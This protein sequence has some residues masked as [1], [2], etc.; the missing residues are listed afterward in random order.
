MEKEFG[1]T[2][3]LAL[4]LPTQPNQAGISYD[5]YIN[6][7]P[8]LCGR[9]GWRRWESADDLLVEEFRDKSLHVSVGAGE[10]LALLGLEDD[11]LHGLHLGGRA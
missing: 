8:S 4:T 1:E 9:V 2:A 7:K 5:Y 6:G 3:S 11:V 10:R